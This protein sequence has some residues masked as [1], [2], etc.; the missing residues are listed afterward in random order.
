MNQSIRNHH[1]FFKSISSYLILNFF[2]LA[3]L[4]S[5]SMESLEGPS[6]FSVSSGR[7]ITTRQFLSNPSTQTQR[8]RILSLLEK[9]EV[10]KKLQEYGLTPTEAASRVQS[11]SDTEIGELS[12]KLDQLPA[13][14][15]AF[16]AVLGTVLA[17][18]LILLVTDI[19]CLTKV[20]PFTRC[21]SGGRR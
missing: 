19:L 7:M 10:Q 2:F 14:Q 12:Q 3:P 17:V 6:L 21:A 5:F 11:L 9:Q 1:L 15:D 18:F 20:F 13:G 16:G 8:Q 4:Q